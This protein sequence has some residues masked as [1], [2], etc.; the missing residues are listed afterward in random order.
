MLGK[1]LSDIQNPNPT[2]LN[3]IAQGFRVGRVTRVYDADYVNS[4]TE[5]EKINY[6]KVEVL[7]LDGLSKVPKPVETCRSWISWKRGA[8]I[9][10]MPE[11]DDIVVCQSRDNGYPV[12]VGFLPY[13]WN[14]SLK[15]PEEVTDATVGL[16]HPLRK[17]EIL[18]KSSSQAEV[19]LSSEGTIKLKS[20][21]ASNT[22][23]VTTLLEENCTE[24]FFDRVISNNTSTVSE[25]TLGYTHDFTGALKSC[26]SSAQ[27]FESAS[28]SYTEDSIT[29]PANKTNTF[30]LFN[31][32]E[33]DHVVS[34][35]ILN[36]SDNNSVT[37]KEGQYNI[38]TEFVYLPFEP[39]AGEYLFKP[40][41][42]EKNIVKYTLNIPNFSF[43][44]ENIIV[45]TVIIKKV[46]GAIRLNSAG[47]LFLDGRNVIVRSQN[48]N[49]SL[50]LAEDGTTK[51]RG[52]YTDLGNNLEGK[53][54]LNKA[55]ITKEVGNFF[56]ASETLRDVQNVATI[57]NPK[58]FYVDNAFPLIKIYYASAEE[59]SAGEPSGWVLSGVSKEEYDSFSI[60]QKN[61]VEKTYISQAEDSSLIT[62]SFILDLI[63]KGFP[64]YAFLKAGS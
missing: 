46:L 26:G 36:K 44:S 58:L 31:D 19:F 33:I 11:I 1:T 23:N 43:V 48:V 9:F 57:D 35:S 8:G 52:I 59:V 50:S 28:V 24:Q 20:K 16:L 56:P 64:S 4:A 53:V 61:S 17:G 34:V 5:S 42:A 7:W 62:Q 55:G 2:E 38:S 30:Y 49:S 13:K 22:E 63:Q 18:I 51:L 41:N 21:D 37:L 10:F 27:V 32:S 14:E 15:R 39:K 47:D 6:G 29:L 45:L 60:E 25:T 40:C 54:L 3:K 12:I